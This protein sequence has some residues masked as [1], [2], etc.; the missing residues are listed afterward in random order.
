VAIEV[1]IWSDMLDPAHNARDNYYGVVGDFTGSWEHV[2]KDLTI[3]CW[4]HAIRDQSLE[5]FSIRGFRTF[6][7]AY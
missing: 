6:G 5:F 2:P 4:Y 3:L 7:A 1:M